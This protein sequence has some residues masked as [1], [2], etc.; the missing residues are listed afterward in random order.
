MQKLPVDEVALGEFCRRWKIAKLETFGSSSRPGFGGSGEI[1]LLVT[2]C[3]D[4]DWGLFDHEQMEWEL[5]ELLGRKV[6]LVSRR[7]VEA[8]SNG[9]FKAP[10]LNNIQLLY[11]RN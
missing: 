8:S 11:E 4:A 3:P 2:F 5:S 6:E 10:V 7:A 1:A 9:L